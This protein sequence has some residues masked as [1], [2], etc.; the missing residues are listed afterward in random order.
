M[1]ARLTSFFIFIEKQENGKVSITIEAYFIDIHTNEVVI[2]LLQGLGTFVTQAAE[3]QAYAKR[4]RHTTPCS[5][6]TSPIPITLPH[7][8]FL[9]CPYYAESSPALEVLARVISIHFLIGMIDTGRTA[10]ISTRHPTPL[11]PLK[12]PTHEED[13]RD[14]ADALNL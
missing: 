2:Q 5:S 8:I 10:G 13:I 12:S 7:W 3:A 4:T 6:S 11:K 14:Q 1:G 9:P